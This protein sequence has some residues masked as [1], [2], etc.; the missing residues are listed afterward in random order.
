M[1][2]YLHIKSFLLQEKTIELLG[3]WSPFSKNKKKRSKNKELVEE[4][5]SFIHRPKEGIGN[6]SSFG[7]RRTISISNLQTNSRKAQRQAQRSSEE[8]E[9]PQEQLRQ[10]QLEHTFPTRI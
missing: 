9:R 8:T 7:E 2:A 3:G 1:N 5:K 10:S 4:T 6:D